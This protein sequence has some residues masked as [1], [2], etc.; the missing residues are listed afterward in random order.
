ML[1][2]RKPNMVGKVKR[3]LISLRVCSQCLGNSW[4]VLGRDLYNLKK[5]YSDCLVV[6]DLRLPKVGAKKK[7]LGGYCSVVD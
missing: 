7:Q 5:D 3:K 1:E 6:I 4:I 2:E